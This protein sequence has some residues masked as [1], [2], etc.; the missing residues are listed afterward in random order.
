MTDALVDTDILS[1]LL[2]GRNARVADRAKE[3]IS[4]T[5]PLAISAVTLMEVAT[6]LEKAGRIHELDTYL[7]RLRPLRCSSSPQKKPALREPS[8]ARS[9]EPEQRS[10]APIQ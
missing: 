3:R 5:G 8:A 9:N 2:R 4:C 10:V 6:G 1:E 7:A